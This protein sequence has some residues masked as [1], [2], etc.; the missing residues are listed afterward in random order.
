MFVSQKVLSSSTSESLLT[1]SLCEVHPL[2]HVEPFRVGGQVESDDVGW[3]V[4][5]ERHVTVFVA[6]LKF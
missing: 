6:L 4:G 1:A 5:G 3:A 2:L